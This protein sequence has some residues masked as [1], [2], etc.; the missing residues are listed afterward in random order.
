MTSTE[1]S[2]FSATVVRLLWLRGHPCCGNQWRGVR[3]SGEESDVRVPQ[4]GRGTLCAA[5]IVA[6]RPRTELHSRDR[7]SSLCTSQRL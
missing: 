7:F 3:D 4:E 6:E 1:Q 2:F 5:Q